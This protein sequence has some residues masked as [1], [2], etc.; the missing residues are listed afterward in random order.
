M[1]FKTFVYLKL[2][3]YIH[4]E[5]DIYIESAFKNFNIFNKYKNMHKYSRLLE[6]STNMLF[7][8][9]IFLG[10]CKL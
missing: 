3:I 6:P 9:G 8:Y 10:F 5:Y 4:F 1:F 2:I 7:C